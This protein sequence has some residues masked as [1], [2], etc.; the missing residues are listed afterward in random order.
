MTIHVPALAGRQ[1]LYGVFADDPTTGRPVWGMERSKVRAV[2][3][4]RKAHGYVTAMPLP[5]PSSRV[6]DA[7]TFRVCSD[8][9]ADFR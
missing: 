9:I 7:P 8:L 2:R 1:C 4:A 3:A 5:D 6:W